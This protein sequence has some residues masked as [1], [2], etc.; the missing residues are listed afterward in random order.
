MENYLL[1]Q[2]YIKYTYVFK[3]KYTI[4]DFFFFTMDKSHK[5]EMQLKF[6]IS[7]ENIIL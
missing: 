1:K 2:Q 7:H 6:W 5:E 4:E 3:R